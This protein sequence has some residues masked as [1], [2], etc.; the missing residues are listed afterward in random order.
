MI[1]DAPLIISALKKIYTVNFFERTK[2][3]FRVLVFTIISQR[4][5]DTSTIKA[6][7]RLFQRYGT[8][9]VMAEAHLG[10]IE[11]LIRESGFYKAKARYIRESS[12]IIL[13]KHNGCL[14]Y[15]SPS[16]RDRTRSRMPSSA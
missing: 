14:L 3:P 7:K 8:P 9:E 5:R 11:Q 10:V 16:P 6:A 12:R 1:K 2:D 13:A 15:T 4:N